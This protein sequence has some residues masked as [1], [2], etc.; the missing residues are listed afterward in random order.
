MCVCMCVFVCMSLWVGV[1]Q[2]C[3]C[4]CFARVRGCRIGA[5][6][7][8]ATAAVCATPPADLRDYMLEMNYF[9]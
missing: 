4:V 2:V 5:F 1:L 7:F 3:V 9:K 8:F 6:I